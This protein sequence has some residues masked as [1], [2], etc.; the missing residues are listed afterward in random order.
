MRMPVVGHDGELLA[1]QLCIQHELPFYGM[2]QSHG[3][4][5]FVQNHPA[6]QE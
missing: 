5:E 6:A 2:L 3:D 1:V 4:A